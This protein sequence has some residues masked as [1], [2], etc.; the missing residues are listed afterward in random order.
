[1]IG[2]VHMGGSL[3]DHYVKDYGCSCLGIIMA[4]LVIIGIILFWPSAFTGQIIIT[5]TP[6]DY[7]FS[8]I[9][10]IVPIVVLVL[11]ARWLSENGRISHL[12]KEL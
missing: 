9:V 10:V 12:E 2:S 3:S 1:M 5:G 6:I 4:L 7:V 8:G 11:M